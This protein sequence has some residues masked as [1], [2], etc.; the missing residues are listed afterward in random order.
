MKTLL[1]VIHS[2]QNLGIYG[3]ICIFKEMVY[4]TIFG[5][6]GAFLGSLPF[7]NVAD[8]EKLPTKKTKRK[9]EKI[10]GKR[11]RRERSWYSLRVLLSLF[12]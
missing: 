10:D 2:V 4:S 9:K 8:A 12:S 1:N 11:R 3:S 5:S 7:Q 6:K